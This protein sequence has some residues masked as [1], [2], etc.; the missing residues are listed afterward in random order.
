MHQRQ[1]LTE[2]RLT[3]SATKSYTSARVVI[4][5]RKK[6]SG[7]LD[8]P[9]MVC[10]PERRSADLFPSIIERPEVGMKRATLVRTW[11]IP[12]IM[13][14][15]ACIVPADEHSIYRPLTLPDW[16]VSTP[17]AE[18]VDPELVLSTYQ[19][20]RAHPTI[21][22]LLI[23]KNDRLI[24]ERY[25][26]GQDYQ[27]AHN[28]ASV[29]KSFTS[30]LAGI[31]LRDGVLPGLEQTMAGYFPDIDWPELDPRKSQITIRQILQM[32]SGFPWEEMT[33]QLDVLLSNWNWIPLIAEFQLSADPGTRFGYSNLTAHL[34][35]IILARAANTDLRSWAKTRLFD[36]LGIE[37]GNW[38]RDASGYYYGAS[39]L[40]LTPRAM[41]KYGLLY[42][43]GGKLKGTQII[44]EEWVAASLTPYS[45]D[46]YGA[47]ISRPGSGKI[48]TSFDLLDYGYL[49]WS[50]KCGRHPVQWAWGHGGNLIVLVPDLNMV[51][52][53]SADNL[54]GQFGQ[55]SWTKEKAIME[56]AGGFITA[57]E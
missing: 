16:E 57:L 2:A 12:L 18:G 37:I 10:F 42:L 21:Y 45:F 51:V 7:G 47:A 44:P 1:A 32:R 9:N 8:L 13:L 56:M 6:L 26:N 43:R 15:A 19:S 34:M 49:W 50:S 31:A 48:L 11:L 25:F 52:V 14:A 5:L 39:D 38:N 23:V 4:A 54:P 28:M 30:S 33:G 3:A 46:A 22:S 27:G 55:A 41:A 29:T 20:A 53:T 35:A 24:A 17:Q 36:P 40:Y